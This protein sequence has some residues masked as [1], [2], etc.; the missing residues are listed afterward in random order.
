MAT[1]GLDVLV[2]GRR[3]SVA[4]ATGARSL[5][6]AGTRPFGAAAVLVGAQRSTHLL[7]TW[8]E[9]V[10][11]EIPFE[12]LYGLTWNPAVM[13]QALAGIPGVA[14]AAR[15]GV[16][17]IAPGF[18]RAVTR[19]APK[20][21]LVPADSL[22]WS[23]RT[24]K[25][26]AELER[27]G[28]AVAVARGAVDVATTALARGDAPVV[29][30]A[31]TLRALGSQGCTVPT[32]APLV[33]AIPGSNFVNVDFGVL[34]DGYEGGCG[35]PIRSMSPEM[36]SAPGSGD[37]DVREAEAAHARLVAACRSGAGAAQLRAAAA[38]VDRWLVRGSGMGF[39]PPVVTDT[40]CADVALA[41]D[42]VLS[43]EVEAGGVRWR[44]LVH[45]G[46]DGPAPF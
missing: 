15:I 19:L 39:E 31:A 9:G 13:G 43:V 30:K 21:E 28:A 23:A 24:T 3:D 29:A 27:I 36:G 40:L 45:I 2:L 38:E 41:A 10:P 35:R 26:P 5:W 33:Q 7:S 8:E 4:Y 1:G 14:D 11:P 22:L 17:A 6:T 25:L 37:I 18:A 42:M 46:R 44:D 34:V 12:R 32:S 20:A 16:D